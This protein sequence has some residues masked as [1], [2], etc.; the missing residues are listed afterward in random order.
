[1]NDQLLNHPPDR[2]IYSTRIIAASPETVYAAFE[3]PELLKEWWGPEGFTNTF[4]EF[5]FREGGTWRYVMHGPEAGHYKNE[6]VFLKIDKPNLIAWDRSSQPLFRMV[7]T[8]EDAGEG[9][10]KFSFRM[11]FDTKENCD[12]VKKFAAD[13]NEENFDRL[14]AVLN[15][16]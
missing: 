11:Q 13:K 6:G 2:E 5:D 4:E 8:F 14:E 12:K 15:K 10:T 1:M 7:L 9:K 3:D 16:Q